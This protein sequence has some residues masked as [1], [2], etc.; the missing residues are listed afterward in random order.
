M[1]GGGQGSTR[2]V[3]GDDGEMRW[4]GTTG[5]GAGREV[6]GRGEEEGKR[7][8]GGEGGTNGRM[9]GCDS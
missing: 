9:V 7:E 5:R 2:E 4:K 6:P 8:E 3:W 1:S